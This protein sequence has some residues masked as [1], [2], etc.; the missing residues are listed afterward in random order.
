MRRLVVALL[1]LAAAPAPYADTPLADARAE[2]Q[3]RAL[4]EELRCL[5]CQNQSIADSNADMA[6]D[7]RSIVRERIAAGQ[8]PA[9]VKAYLIERYGDWVTFNPPLSARTAPLWAL[10]LLLLA[11]GAVVALRLFRRPR[12]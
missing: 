2:A 1:L 7:M 4:M 11:V 6:G 8:S 5:V 9:E 3:A 12:A 10:P